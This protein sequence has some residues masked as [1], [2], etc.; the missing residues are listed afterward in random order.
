[1][2]RVKSAITC[3]ENRAALLNEG[4]H[5]MAL[6]IETYNNIK[7]GESYFKA[8]GH[9]KVVSKARSLVS[10]L[11]QHGPVA[12]YDPHGNLELFAEIYPLDELT[13]HAAY[14]QDV[15]QLDRQILSH[16]AQPITDLGTS[17]AR[18]IF[19]AA[20]DASRLISHIRH[21]LPDDA[22]VLS[23]D[24]MRLSEDMLT[25]HRR[26][27]SPLNFATNFAFFRDA[28]AHHTRLVTANYWAGYGAERTALWLSLHGEDGTVLAEWV[29]ALPE[30][31]GS[32]VIDSSDVR[33]RF[34]LDEFVGQLF[35]HVIGAAGHEIIKYAL[36][37]YG[38]RDTILSCTH[39]A[40]AWPADYYAGLPAPRDEEQVI[41]WVQ[42]SHPCPIPAGGLGLNL[43]GSGDTRWLDREIAPFA[44]YALDVA[45]LL[46]GVG[47]PSQIE[48]QAGKHLVRPRY[49]A[50][51]RGGRSRI[52]HVNV[53]R[54]DL[55]PDPRIPELSNLM[56]KGYLLPASVLPTERFSS[57]ALPTPMA[58]C[59]RDLPIAALIYDA[60]GREV[61]RHRFGRVPRNDCPS[62]DIDQV[63]A[64]NGA[65]PSGYGHLELV[66]DFA[67]GGD[68][69]GWLHGIFRYED[70]SNGHTAE[71]S[72]GSHIFNSVLSYRSEPQSYAGPPPGLSTR[73]FLRLGPPPLE[74]ICHLIYPASTPW[75]EHSETELVLIDGHGEEVAHRQ[76]DIPCSGSL[77][78]RY[79]EMFDASER[80]RAGYGAYVLVRD[81]HCRLF[82]YH[83]LLNGEASFSYDH[84]FGF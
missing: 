47:W 73:L 63:L 11:C 53:E 83:G 82:G 27:L 79:S 59:Q 48:V 58:T 17:E 31:A 2:L 33:R 69:D 28:A 15:N 55:E 56:G 43:M 23:L 30:S 24:D 50:I 61:A 39:D 68:A 77:L 20:F 21:L 18:A 25:D 16:R 67:D 52:A 38:D 1:M 42:N 6:K 41:L 13:I 71:T 44:T 19:V 72:F 62:L 37:T 7:G 35:M 8:I 40:N 46:P 4:N 34:G 64:A 74:T 12:V 54:T 14:V 45:E 84:M 36:D 70:R 66:Y 49:E 9:P 51:A 29:E 22:I 81:A 60:T 80:R 75:I 57:T 32:I 26:Y 78:F 3:R 76:I 10:T 5:A 65:L